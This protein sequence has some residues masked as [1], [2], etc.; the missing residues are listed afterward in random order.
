MTLA[1]N[2]T[3]L[4]E[5]G[6][7]IIGG[8][9]P[10]AKEAAQ[11]A[12]EAGVTPIDV[13]NRGLLPGMAVVGDRFK[14]NEYYIPE[15]LLAARAMKGALALVQPLLGATDYEPVGTVV[16]GTVKGDL[17]DIGKNLVAMMLEGAGFRVVDLGVDVS[18]EKFVAAAREH[19]AQIVGLSALLTTTMVNM[20]ATI[21]AFGAAGLREAVKIVVGG[22]PVTQRWAD[23]IGAD[24]FAPDA[25]S[26]VDVARQLLGLEPAAVPSPAPAAAPAA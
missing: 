19:K 1:V 23:E 6:E 14:R 12:L 7:A 16:V 8:D 13:V 11:R 4:R 15:V 25:A 24:G 20:R 10:G 9:A 5:L 18:A 2:D 26:G 17:H 21:E 3:A 22:A